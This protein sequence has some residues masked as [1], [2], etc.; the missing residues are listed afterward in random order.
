MT[1]I[2]QLGFTRV[3]LGLI[4]GGYRC[5]Q[6]NPGTFSSFLSSSNFFAKCHTKR[7]VNTWINYQY[8]KHY[9]PYKCESVEV[10]KEYEHIIC[11][12]DSISTHTNNY[13]DKGA[14]RGIYQKYL[15][16]P[17]KFVT[18]DS[19]VEREDLINDWNE[20][21]ALIAEMG[22]VPEEADQVS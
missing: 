11:L 10:V 19:G 4:K 8:P 21:T 2:W 12:M 9:L 14:A 6:V 15:K 20:I 18:L 17:T 7:R 1:A 5:A 22:I 16:V 3:V 13:G